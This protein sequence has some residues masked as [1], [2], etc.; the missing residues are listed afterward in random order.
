MSHDRRIFRAILPAAATLLLLAGSSA[1]AADAITGI[2]GRPTDRSVTLNVRA[3][4][5][6]EIYVEYGSAPGSY[7]SQTAPATAAALA[8]TEFLMDGL[9]PDARFWYRIRH[10][11]AGSTGAYDAGPERT[12]HTRRAAGSPFTFC[13]QG[14]SHPERDGRMFDGPFYSRTLATVAADQ[15]DFY[16]TIGD[17]FSIDAL[18]TVDAETVAGR[19]TLQLPYLG[20]VGSSSSL[21]LVNGNHEQAARY[22]LD[23]TPDNPA[24]WAQNA[25]NRFFPQ[26]APDAFYTGNTEVVPFIGLLRNTYAWTWGDALFVVIDPYWSSPVAVDN[27]FGGGSKTSD[28]WQITLGDAQYFWL[29]KTLEE[30]AARWKFIFAHHPMGTGRGGVELA[31][32]F[33]WG[34]KNEDGTWGFATRRPG[35][36]LPIHQLMAANHVTVFFQGHDHLFVRQELDGVV[37]QELPNPADPTYAL[38]NADAYA[39]GDKLANTGYVRVN[40]APSLVRVEYVRTYLPKD[41]NATHHNGEVAFSY[42]LSGAAPPPPAAT[43]FLPSSARTPGV[44][45]AFWT[46]DL[47]V[48]NSGALDARLTIT[49]LGHGADGRTG[50][51]RTFSL[52]AGR[53]VTYA[54]V[55]GSVFGLS[56]GWGAIRVASSTTSLV[57]TSQTSTLAPG[58]GTYGQSLPSFGDPD[59]IRPGTA[60]SLVGIRED[61]AFRTN[62]VLASAVEEPVDVDVVLVA[63]SGET[64]GQTRVALPP[65]GMSQ[66]N[67]VVRLLGVAADVA[68][69]RLVVST[70][71]PAGAFAA[72]ASVIDAITNDPRTLLPR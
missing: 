69:A 46:T 30:S 19:Y 55:L 6:L 20:L 5:P 62:L 13:V 9:M 58:G 22:L 38:N 48:A 42:A 70:P 35:W 23:G 28:R 49:F 59:L 41:E 27:V 14:D 65:L 47:T 66:L 3:D 44:G 18:S 37:Y 7:T 53:S 21:F 72:C 8:P 43:W 64:L 61:S 52:S 11:S 25:R 36:P 15:P 67:R 68:G 16:L 51:E 50:P 29:K 31:P 10:R 34:G 60:Q 1:A 71:T 57:V 4:A 40:V 32:Y 56:E 54:D 39:T 26:P 33:E 17:D 24:V 2:L 12:F 63:E 45:G